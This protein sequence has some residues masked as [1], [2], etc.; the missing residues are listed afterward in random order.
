MQ[1]TGHA[2]VLGAGIAGLLAAR[3]LTDT[4][5]HVTVIERTGS[6]TRTTPGAAYRKAGTRTSSCPAAHR[7]ST[8]SCPA[9]STS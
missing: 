9:S 4:Y 3:V 2:V 5:D 7:S 8:S 6:P 1:R